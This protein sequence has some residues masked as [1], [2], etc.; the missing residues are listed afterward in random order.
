MAASSSIRCNVRD[1][2]VQRRHSLMD[3]LRSASVKVDLGGNG[4]R[5][6]F[7]KAQAECRQL[8]VAIQEAKDRLAAHRAEHGC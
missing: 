6:A 3:H 5:D 8:H 2:L 4:D 1:N 7:A